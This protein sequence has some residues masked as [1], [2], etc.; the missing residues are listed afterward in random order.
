[1]DHFGIGT[2][3]LGAVETYITAARQTGR[4]TSLLESLR[5]GDRVVCRTQGEANDLDMRC[6]ERGLKVAFLVVPTY[7]PNQVFSLGKGTSKGRTLFDHGWLEDYYKRLIRDAQAAV[8]F[9]QRE[10]SGYGTA[11]LETKRQAL[12]AARWRL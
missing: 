4:T 10:T 5:D 6:Q 11:H 3:V 2:G 9:V 1:M 8:D 12:E 7:A